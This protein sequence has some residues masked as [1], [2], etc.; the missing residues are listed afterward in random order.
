MQKTIELVNGNKLRV[1]VRKS[2]YRGNPNGFNVR[3][4]ELNHP[5]KLTTVSRH[6]GLTWKEAF[7]QAL[8][9]WQKTQAMLTRPKEDTL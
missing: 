6:L 8:T 3:I 5:L 9:N 1:T 7:D 4:L 2:F